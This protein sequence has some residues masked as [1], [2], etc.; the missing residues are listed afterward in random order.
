MSAVQ[1]Y[2]GGPT[3]S[4]L[5]EDWV[6]GAGALELKE[7]RICRHLDNPVEQVARGLTLGG[8]RDDRTEHAHA[9]DADHG[10]ADIHAHR[11]HALVMRCVQRLVVHVGLRLV[12]DG[13]VEAHLCERRPYGFG[14]LRLFSQVEPGAEG[15]VEVPQRLGAVLLLDRDAGPYADPRLE[16]HHL[17]VVVWH[18]TPTVQHREAHHVEGRPDVTNLLDLEHPPG[19]HPRPRAERVEPEIYGC[20][21]GDHCA[22]T[23][24]GIDAGDLGGAFLMLSLIHIS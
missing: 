10:R 7:A 19:C 5:G 2:R 12:G 9:V 14:R 6:H 15:G 23:G 11:I 16:V 22:T 17:L 3:S 4:G 21:H 1:G 13:G 8:R 18:V 24:S 20:R